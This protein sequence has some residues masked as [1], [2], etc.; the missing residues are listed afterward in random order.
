MGRKLAMATAAGGSYNRG[1]M[2]RLPKF[3]YLVVVAL[4]LAAN[5][6]LAQ[7][8][9][10]DLAEVTADSGELLRVHGS[11]GNGAFGVPVAGGRD[12]DGDGLADY[13]LAAM[14]A[15]PLGRDR[16]GLIQ[17]VFGDG[18]IAGIVDTSIV[19]P[20]VLRIAGSA[21]QENAGNEMWIDDVTGDGIAD[22]MIGRQNYSFTAALAGNGALSIIAGGPALRQLAEAGEII[23]LRQPPAELT[24]VTLIGGQRS[25]RLGMWVRSGDVDGDG[26]AD[27]LLGA[28]Q[29]DH[30]GETHS[31]S[32]YV[33]RGGAHLGASRTVSL[34]D[35]ASSG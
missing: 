9:R 19:Q 1:P 25:G 2:F 12:C 32:V 13:A 8:H 14:L 28:D 11:S 33:I 5:T 20:R 17:L 4:A 22:L 7:Y 3:A 16:A 23:D 29:E 26:I 6:V 34:A 24:M 10:I 31:G 30:I 35:L 21:R 15:S 18:T 27:V